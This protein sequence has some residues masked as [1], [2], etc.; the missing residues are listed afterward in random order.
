MLGGGCVVVQDFLTNDSVTGLGG[1]SGYKDCANHNVYIY[2]MTL[3]G[4]RYKGK[5]LQIGT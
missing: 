4:N 1:K 5:W 2:K 3:I